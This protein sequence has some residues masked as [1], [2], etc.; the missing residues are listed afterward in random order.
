MF[1]Y[2]P[3]VFMFNIYIIAHTFH[4]IDHV[5]LNSFPLRPYFLFILS[6]AHT[7]IH[8]GLVHVLGMHKQFDHNFQRQLWSLS[9]SNKSKEAKFA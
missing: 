8:I 9:C 1:F 7:A 4:L 2:G 3:D 5:L 6:C